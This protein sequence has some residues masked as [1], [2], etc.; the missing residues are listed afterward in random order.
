[1]SATILAGRTLVIRSSTEADVPA[2]VAIYR[3]HIS[4]GI[5]DLGAYEP[6]PV[7]TD[8]LKRRRRNMRAKRLP[9]LVAALDDEV[10]GYAY[11]VPFR[12]RPAYRYTLKHSIYIHPDRTGMGIGR[13]L[14]PALV[15][16][17]AAGGYRQMIG[18]IDGGNEA[19]LRLHEHC[20][21]RRVGVLPAVAFKFG[22][23]ADSVL[24]Q[25]ELGDGDGSA[26]MPLPGRSVARASNPHD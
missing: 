3:H 23:W 24:V 7:E 4:R 2:M 5:G 19:S 8:D 9:H 12:K 15:E 6:D 13:L 14:L 26:P 1:M 11:A 20:G 22:H 25:R 10:A 16:A 17:C 21:F 18:Y